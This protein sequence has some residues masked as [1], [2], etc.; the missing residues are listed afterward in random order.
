MGGE[1]RAESRTASYERAAEIIKA[2]CSPSF[3][4][5]LREKVSGEKSWDRIAADVRQTVIASFETVREAFV[6]DP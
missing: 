3:R 4:D 5:S 1:E 2:G 6:I